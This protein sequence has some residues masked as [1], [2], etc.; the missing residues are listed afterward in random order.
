MRPLDADP[1]DFGLTTDEEKPQR[2]S[3]P[4][5][6]ETKYFIEGTCREICGKPEDEHEQITKFVRRHLKSDPR[7]AFLGRAHPL[8][9]FF[10]WRLRRNKAKRGWSLK[11]LGNNQ[12]SKEGG[13]GQI[14][15]VGPKDVPNK[16]SVRRESNEIEGPA[17]EEGMISSSKPSGR[18][19]KKTRGRS[20]IRK[21]LG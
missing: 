3:R 13:S 11:A 15:A 21:S 7:Y 2:I 8:H 12:D 6:A 16:T 1:D 10:M 18:K 4:Q 19:R 5:D 9:P 20:G 17:I 14:I